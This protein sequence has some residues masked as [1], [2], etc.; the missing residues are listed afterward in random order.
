M[1]VT[2]R[3]CVW[4]RRARGEKILLGKKGRGRREKER[5]GSFLKE[6]GKL[7]GGQISKC[8]VWLG[9]TSAPG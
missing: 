2:V 7:E 5:Q 4:L 3:I 9:L 8:T 6:T 1:C